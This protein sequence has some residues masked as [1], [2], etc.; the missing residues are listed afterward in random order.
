MTTKQLE[1]MQVFKPWASYNYGDSFQSWVEWMS[2]CHSMQSFVW[3][4]STA[5]ALQ[6]F[7]AMNQMAWECHYKHTAFKVTE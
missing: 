7:N 5:D 1:Q 2:T 6:L 3:K 4:L